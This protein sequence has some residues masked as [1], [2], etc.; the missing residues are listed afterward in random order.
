MSTTNFISARISTSLLKRVEEYTQTTGESKT[1]ILVKALTA[2]LD[3]WKTT[4][5]NKDSLEKKVYE[6]EKTCK[7]LLNFQNDSMYHK[8]DKN[9]FARA[10]ALKELAIHLTPALLPEALE[11]ARSI[12]DEL[13]RAKAIKALSTNLPKE[14]LPLALEIV[15]DIKNDFARAKAM[16]ALAPRLPKVLP[17][18]LQIARNIENDSDRAVVLSELAPYLPEVLSEA[19]EAVRNTNQ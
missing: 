14:L 7:V 10:K 5:G 8:H 16:T 3:S 9:D 18:V 6:L 4:K 17:E 2:Y 1:D 12:E 19:L 13:A 15:R 11:T